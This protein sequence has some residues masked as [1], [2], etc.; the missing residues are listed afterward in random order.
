MDSARAGNR[1]VLPG[2]HP[3]KDV[4]GSCAVALGHKRR[5][6]W[7]AVGHLCKDRLPLTV[8][9]ALEHSV[10]TSQ[11]PVSCSVLALRPTCSTPP[12]TAT[13]NCLT[14]RLTSSNRGCLCRT[15]PAVMSLLHV[16]HTQTD[17][18]LSPNAVRL[19]C[20]KRCQ[21]STRNASGSSTILRQEAVMLFPSSRPILAWMMDFRWE[22][23]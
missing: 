18:H 7:H 22:N 4:S 17:R 6:R 14:S 2:V 16:V 19:D 12:G 21:N 10:R 8:L 23:R 3:K 13:P 9:K 11:L 20:K 5:K 15:A 1:P